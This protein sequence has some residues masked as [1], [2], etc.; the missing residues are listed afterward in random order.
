LTSE[1]SRRKAADLDFVNQGEPHEITVFYAMK[2]LAFILGG[3]VFK[4]WIKQRFISLEPQTE[5]PAAQSFAVAPQE[6]IRQVCIY[7]RLEE[8]RLKKSRRGTE[9]LPRDVAIYL[10]RCLSRKTLA[11][12]GKAFG[13]SNYSTV[14]RAIERSKKRQERDAFVRK[15]ITKLKLIFATS[16]Q[17]N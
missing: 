16:Q 8:D 6:V 13:I 2:K 4:D 3:E 7:C 9:N 12:I 10:A 1:K 15:D 17:Q 5:M 14:S 11:E